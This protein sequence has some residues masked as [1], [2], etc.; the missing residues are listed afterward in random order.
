MQHR[1][2]RHLKMRSAI[3]GLHAGRSGPA[4]LSQTSTFAEFVPFEAGI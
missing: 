3:T 2:I 4:L 1:H